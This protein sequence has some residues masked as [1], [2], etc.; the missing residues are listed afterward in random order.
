MGRFLLWHLA[1]LREPQGVTT[2]DCETRILLR[3]RR[4][5]PDTRFSQIRKL[6]VYVKTREYINKK[7]EAIKSRN[8]LISYFYTLDIYFLYVSVCA[9]APVQ[10][11]VY[12]H[13]TF[14]SANIC[15]RAIFCN[16]GS[17][18]SSATAIWDSGLWRWGTKDVYT[19][20]ERLRVIQQTVLEAIEARP[21]GTLGVWA[22]WAPLVL[23]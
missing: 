6:L 11:G 14:L 5:S 15:S 21:T 7:E 23:Y 20:P 1:D 2:K 18:R 13:V 9:P 22:K 16:R 4:H 12:T 8:C 3:G 19:R 17:I 10:F